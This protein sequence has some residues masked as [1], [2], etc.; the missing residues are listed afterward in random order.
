VEKN[1]SNQLVEL[2]NLYWEEK[3]EALEKM[4]NMDLNTW[5][6]IEDNKNY[7]KERG[8]FLG[9][10]R[11]TQD[12]KGVIENMLLKRFEGLEEHVQEILEGETFMLI[13]EIMAIKFT[14]REISYEIVG[15]FDF[16]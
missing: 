4:L 12:D 7:L 15:D 1:M 10:R 13:D 11:P 14:T 16:R 8:H 9:R 5:K 3:N 2:M 6:T